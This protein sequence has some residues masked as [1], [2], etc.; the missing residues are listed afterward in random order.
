MKKSNYK[1]IY[2]FNICKS[3]CLKDRNMGV[4]MVWGAL[5]LCEKNL[6]ENAFHMCSST[7]TSEKETIP[8]CNVNIFVIPKYI[9]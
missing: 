2:V 7:S 9:L 3:G 5:R 1:T 6:L 4:K 8:P